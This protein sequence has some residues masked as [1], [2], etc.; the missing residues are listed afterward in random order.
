[1]FND[2]F[3]DTLGIMHDTGCPALDKKLNKNICFGGGSKSSGVT[4]TSTIPDEWKPFITTS[5]G[6]AQEAFQAGDLG[7]VA[8]FDPS[9]EAALARQEGSIEGYDAAAQD[10]E[11]SRQRLRDTSGLKDAAA[12]QAQDAF[13]NFQSQSALG[14]TLGSARN[15]ARGDKFQ[16]DLTR[17]F[18]DLDYQAEKDYQGSAGQAQQLRDAGT[19]QLGEA[20][21]AR[22]AQDQAAGDAQYQ[23]LNRLFGLY[24]SA[25]FQSQQNVQKGGGGK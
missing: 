21:K 7:R 3:E 11:G 10:F 2:I 14:G 8:G 9:Q 20:G 24:G 12:A 19:A 18:A 22:Q 6:D 15:E 1:M 4:K 13:G 16:Q 23:A 25:P 5:L 17:Q